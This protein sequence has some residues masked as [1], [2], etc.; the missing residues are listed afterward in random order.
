MRVGIAKVALISASDVTSRKRASVAT[1]V[2]AQARMIA[3]SS[4]VRCLSDR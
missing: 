1:Q 2:I 4:T 3:S